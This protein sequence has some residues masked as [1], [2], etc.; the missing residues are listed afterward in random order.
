MKSDELSIVVQ[1]LELA[2]STPE[3]PADPAD[4]AGPVGPFNE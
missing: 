1:R 4:P 2:P 3:E